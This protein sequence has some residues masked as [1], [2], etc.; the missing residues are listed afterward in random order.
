MDTLPHVIGCVTYCD[1]NKKLLK[2]WLWRNYLVAFCKDHTIVGAGNTYAGFW[3]KAGT[4]YYASLIY[5]D[6]RQ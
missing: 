1:P 3:T 5:P 6:G 2:E 4:N